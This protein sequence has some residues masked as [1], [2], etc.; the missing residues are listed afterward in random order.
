M[1]CPK[2]NEEV[3]GEDLGDNGVFL[4]YDCECGHSWGSDEEG[5]DRWCSLADSLRKADKEKGV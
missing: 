5:L 3:E 4:N 1:K 2:C